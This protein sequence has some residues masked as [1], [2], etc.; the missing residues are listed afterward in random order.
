MHLSCQKKFL[1][2]DCDTNKPPIANAGSDQIITLPKDSTVLDGSASS[3]PDGTITVFKWAKISGPIA[4]NII[5]TN[6]TKTIVKTLAMGIYKFEL[7]VTDNGGSSAKDTVQVI[8]ND[9]AVNQPPVAKAGSDQTI[10]LPADSILLDGTLSFDPDGTIATYQWNKIS[11]PSSFTIL[12]P[13]TALTKVKSLGQ[14]VYQFELTVTDNASL[15]AKDTIQ[16]IVNTPSTTN[17][18][19][20]ANAGASFSANYDL[21]TCSLSS[22]ITINGSASADPDGT[23]VSYLWTGPGIISNATSVICQVTGLAVGMYVFTLLVTDN[24]GAAGYDTVSVNVTGTNRP[25]IPAQLVPVGTLSF[26]RSHMAVAWAGNKILFAGGIVPGIPGIDPRKEVDIFDVT[27][28]NVIP[29][30]LSEARHSIGAVGYGNKIFFAGG[31]TSTTMSSRI[32]IYDVSTN[33]WSTKELSVARNPSAATAA[34][35]IVFA[36]GV[37]PFSTNDIGYSRVDIYNA[38]NNVWSTTTLTGSGRNIGATTSFGNK[39]YF[40]GGYE[41]VGLHNVIDIY[42]AVSN[43][44]STSMLSQYKSAMAGIAVNNKIYWAGGDVYNTPGGGQQVEIRDLTTSTTS[45]GCLFQ[46]NAGSSY[47]SNSSFDAV[48]KNNKIVF[49]TSDGGA[50]FGEIKNKFD[51]Y[52]ITTNTWSIGVLSQDIFGASIICV[53]NVIYV[54][55]GYVNSVLSNQIWRLDF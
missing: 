47:G 42:D 32:D 53:N 38:T 7:S 3:D 24:N 45:F 54:A 49:F 18:P 36:G 17:L 4:S 14:G 1:C 6:S 46:Q 43:Q 2:P 19:P 41:A 29:A 11:G 50:G 20:V 23:I 22:A 5:N 33:S 16:I 15:S 25:I 8:V 39:I 52:D 35:K 13:N 34:D 12:T 37:E 9:P 30:Q 40:A 10:I 48:V 21:Q 31:I 26:A 51:I 27:T 44:W 55:G 28:N